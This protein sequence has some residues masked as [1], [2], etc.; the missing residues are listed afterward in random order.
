MDSDQFA[1]YQTAYQ[2]LLRL[3]LQNPTDRELNR[4]A[5]LVEAERTQMPGNLA[6]AELLYSA[7]KIAS[8][9]LIHLTTQSQYRPVRFLFL[10][11]RLTLRQVQ[12][13]TELG[14]NCQSLMDVLKDITEK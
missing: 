9:S 11:Y 2:D 3:G 6:L 8:R 7:R 14:Q 13:A 5:S 1:A 4:F 10:P 12:S